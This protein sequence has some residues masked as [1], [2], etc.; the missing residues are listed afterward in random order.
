MQQN[1]RDNRFVIKDSEVRESFET[2]S[3]RDTRD[4]KG[5][6]DLLPTRAIKRLAR[7]FENGAKKYGD[8]NWEKGQPIGR[9]V[10]S[11]I[12]HAFNYLEGQKDEDHLIA[13]V[14]NLLCAADTEERIKEGLLSEEL[15]DLAKD[16]S[17]D[18]KSNT[19]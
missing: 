9:Y 1:I 15:N 6:Y 17:K 12:R 19:N 7:H 5:R 8:R 18:E 13:A 14:W 11:G 16:K 10:D 3:R 4:G 2:G